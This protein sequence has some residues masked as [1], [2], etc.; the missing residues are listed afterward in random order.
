MFNKILIFLFCT[1]LLSQQVF[2]D[3]SVSWSTT[4][5]ECPT[6][7][8]YW[9]IAPWIPTYTTTS[10]PTSGTLVCNNFYFGSFTDYTKAYTLNWWQTSCLPWEQAVWITVTLPLLIT[11]RKFSVTTT[12]FYWDNDSL[13]RSS[14]VWYITSTWTLENVFWNNSKSSAYIWANSNNADNYYEKIWAVTNWSLILLMNKNVWLRL[15]RFDKNSFD[16]TNELIS[17]QVIDWLA[18][19]G[20]GYL[21][22]DLSISAVKNASTYTFNFRD[23]DYALFL[24]N[25]TPWIL[26]YRITAETAALKWIYI[27]PIDDSISTEIRVLWWHMI[28]NYWVYIWKQLEYTLKK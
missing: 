14:I 19:L 12:P 6:Q 27:N 13:W 9:V 22:N 15:V 10:A 24:K 28:I 17:N 21:Q 11:C 26:N 1:F 7:E 18:T 2:A 5:V 23:Y 8:I 25:T 4:N 20:T 3:T 16:T